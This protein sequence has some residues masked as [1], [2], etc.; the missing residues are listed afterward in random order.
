MINYVKA[1]FVTKGLIYWTWVYSFTTFFVVNGAI[2]IYRSTFE[3]SGWLNAGMGDIFF[4]V[5]FLLFCFQTNTIKKQQ[6]LFTQI[7]KGWDATLEDNKKLMVLCE[8]FR[9][10]NEELKKTNEKGS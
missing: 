8:K 5:V 7:F 3:G 4:A 1:Q 10:E 2:K 9:K 6:G